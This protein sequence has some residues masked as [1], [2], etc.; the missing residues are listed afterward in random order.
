MNGP[1]G[2]SGPRGPEGL[3]GPPGPSGHVHDGI[4]G[5]RS[6]AYDR[7]DGFGDPLEQ[8]RPRKKAP[9]DRLPVDMGPM[10]EPIP[11]LASE[12]EKRIN[13]FFGSSRMTRKGLD[14]ACPFCNAAMIVRLRGRDQRAFLGCSK[15]PTCSGSWD[16]PDG[17]QEEAKSWERQMMTF[18]HTAAMLP[19]R[20]SEAAAAAA[21]A[22]RM[23]HARMQMT[24]PDPARFDPDTGEVLDKMIDEVLDKGVPRG[25]TTE[26][27]SE[28][29]K[30]PVWQP[31]TFHQFTALKEIKITA[32]GILIRR[33]QRFHFDGRTLITDG[34]DCEVA[35]MKGALAAVDW[36]RD[37]GPSSIETIAAYKAR[38]AR[39]EEMAKEDEDVE[40][41][42]NGI[43]ARLARSAARAPYRVARM[44]AL[45]EGR[46]A[47][48]K[49]LR[50][51]V[52]P[53]TFDLVEAFLDTDAGQGAVL[54]LV[55]LAGPYTPKIGKNKHVQAVCE[56]F[57][58][59]GVAKGANEVF[60]LLG[61]ILEP[62]LRSVMSSLPEVS[63][64]ADKVVPKRR[65]KRVATSEVRVAKKPEPEEDADEDE[66]E[67]ERRPRKNALRA[68]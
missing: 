51:R 9:I 50:N 35:H 36:V 55:G 29:Y 20:V 64:I 12:A 43:K 42:T 6:K 7:N 4:P 14:L 65:K 48:L 49:A 25:K 18:A 24:S 33:G 38:K 59:E 16:I 11:V 60:G 32:R 41:P 40:V 13:E 68:L 63:E 37:D 47:I 19:D 46:K 44:R 10:E 54:G 62:V 52:Q 17:A 61:M 3:Q 58:D 23:R 5:P 34:R 56:E 67:E 2:P 57:L 39:K 27:Y 30:R 22:E 45:S 31:G 21:D 8:P 28:P 15:Y 66:A 1:T 53:A 26:V